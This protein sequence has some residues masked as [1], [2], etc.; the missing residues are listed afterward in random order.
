MRRRRKGEQQRERKQHSEEGEIQHEHSA[1]RPERNND[2][3]ARATMLDVGSF[4]LS[5]RISAQC[6]PS[7]PFDVVKANPHQPHRTHALNYTW[8]YKLSKDE[9]LLQIENEVLH[10]R[11]LLV[12]FLDSN[13]IICYGD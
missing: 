2:C 8:P 3:S 9:L 13:Y 6:R 12:Q 1:W 11:M 4:V 7:R 5:V 10:Y